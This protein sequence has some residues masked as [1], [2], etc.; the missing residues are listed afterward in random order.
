L[1]KKGPSDYSKKATQGKLRVKVE[2]I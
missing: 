2:K 1:R